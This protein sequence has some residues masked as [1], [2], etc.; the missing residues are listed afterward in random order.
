MGTRCNIRLT[1][2]DNRLY[3][4]RHWDGYPAETGADLCIDL[5]LSRA[6]DMGI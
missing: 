4:Y 5:A 1:W 6:V 3:F 2:G